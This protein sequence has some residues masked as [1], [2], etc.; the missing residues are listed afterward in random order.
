MSS[1]V[2]TSLA[3][4]KGSMLRTEVQRATDTLVVLFQQRRSA[5]AYRHENTLRVLNQQIDRAFKEKDRV[6]D[7]LHKH[8]KGHGCGAA[9]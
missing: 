1:A 5:F 6:V 2:P 8:V 9:E 4:A 7:A 3:C